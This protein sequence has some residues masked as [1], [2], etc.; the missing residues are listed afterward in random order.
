M[1]AAR[2]GVGLELATAAALSAA[3]RVGVGLELAEA[4]EEAR[5]G[6][7]TLCACTALSGL[8]ISGLFSALDPG[9]FGCRMTSCC[10]AL[11][12]YSSIFGLEN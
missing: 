4:A 6:V 1:E 3:A 7:A 8:R 2:D 11:Y 10:V 5:V 9:L 12:L